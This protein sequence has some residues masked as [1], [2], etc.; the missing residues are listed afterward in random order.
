MWN[1]LR[2][3]LSEVKTRA[4]VYV[5][6]LY[7]YCSVQCVYITDK[8]ESL[9]NNIHP[10]AARW[11]SGTGKVVLMGSLQILWLSLIIHSVHFGQ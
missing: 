5:S 7:M 10:E 11:C 9:V 3:V 6:V 2:E 8:N 4:C 1:I